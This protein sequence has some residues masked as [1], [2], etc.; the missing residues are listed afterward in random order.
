MA[1]RRELMLR[2]GHDRNETGLAAQRER[3]FV[4]RWV[5]VAGGREAVIL[6]ADEQEIARCLF[7][8]GGDPRDAPQHGP[9]EVEL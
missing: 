3:A 8:R 7:R 9:L 1:D 5:R 6:V 4:A 2:G